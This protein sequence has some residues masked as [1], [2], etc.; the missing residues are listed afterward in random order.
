MFVPIRASAGGGG[1]DGGGG[2]GGG[3]DGGGGSG[4]GGGVGGGADWGG[5]GDGGDCGR[6]AAA[7]VPGEAASRAPAAATAAATAATTVTG[8]GSRADGT[9]VGGTPPGRARVTTPVGGDDARSVNGAAAARGRAAAAAAATTATVT[10]TTAAVVCD[11]KR[12]RR[13]GRAGVPMVP[14][15]IRRRGGHR[16]E[17]EHDGRGA[18]GNRGTRGGRQ[19]RAERGVLARCPQVPG[20]VDN[21][22]GGAA[23]H[24]GA[25]PST[26]GRSRR[27]CRRQVRRRHWAA[28]AQTRRG[29]DAAGRHAAGGTQGRQARGGAEFR[30]L[31]GRAV[32]AATAAAGP[33]TVAAGRVAA[34]DTSDGGWAGGMGA[35]TG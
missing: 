12:Q 16:V 27:S 4:G 17:C 5:G 7:V 23:G 25:P 13:R 11:R 28:G 34:K 8:V 22:R 9:P 6:S 18:K 30:S 2:V 14:D 21:T 1:G 24:G 26:A 19:G 31:P 10:A 32:T 15:Q 29:R 3:N 33:A 35:G 20:V